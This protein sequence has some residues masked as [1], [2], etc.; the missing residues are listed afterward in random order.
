[1]YLGTT[2]TAR[3]TF[4]TSAR[5]GF[6]DFAGKLCV[7]HPVDGI[8]TSTDGVT[9]TVNADADSPKGTC[10][11]P[12]Q[13]K[14]FASGA[15]TT[16]VYWSAA[17]DP[18][19]W[20]PA[21]FVDIRE[22]ND[23]P[24]I[25]LRGASGIDVVGRTGLLAFKRRSHHRIYDSATGAYETVDPNVG[26]ASALA[27]TAIDNRTIFLSE[28]GIFESSGAGPAKKVSNNL[29]PLFTPSQINYGQLDLVCSGRR[30][31]RAYFSLPRA[32]ST[33]NDLALEYDNDTEEGWI[34]PGSNAMTSYA[35]FGS[36]TER[37][38][39]GHPTV[40]GQ[41]YNLFTGGSDDG[42]AIDWRFQTKW[43]EPASGFLMQPWRLRL[44]GRGEGLLDTRLDY[45]SQVGLAQNFVLAASNEI[46]YDTGLVYDIGLLYGAAVTQEEGEILLCQPCKAISFR[47]TGSS[48][49]SEFA[50]PIFE[51]GV[52]P[53]V[54]SFALY[55]LQLIYV[56]L[57][58]A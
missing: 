1:L 43:F 41:V 33:A 3:K 20:A 25:A 26:C 54:G 53:E 15:G 31:G 8:W 28:R 47:L 39:G 19:V 6:A 18:T 29:D 55:G 13:N 46:L 24:V 2:N 42:A 48:S 4:T 34:A 36:S 7:I 14:L 11:W 44:Q 10:L 21:D 5:V 56:P 22:G 57:T 32:S 52:G 27:V 50:Q 51:Q 58:P 35:T 49:T 17:G 16:R 23:D 9:Y 38:Y 37:L 30:H 40:S 45:E 12:F